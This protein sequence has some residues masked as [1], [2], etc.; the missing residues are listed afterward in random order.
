MNEL[1]KFLGPKYF[2]QKLNYYIT[3]VLHSKVTKLLVVLEQ[4]ELFRC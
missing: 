2:H 3:I 1:L 4:T